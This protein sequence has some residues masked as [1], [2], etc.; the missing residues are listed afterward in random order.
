MTHRI[1]LLVVALLALLAVGCATIAG[2]GATQVVN[3][4][5]T[6]VGAE[7]W[8]GKYKNGEV[9]DL[10]NTGHQ[11]PYSVEISRKNVVVV[12]K[13]QGFKDTN[14]V[15]TQQVNGWFLGNILIGGIVGS[16]ID[17]STGASMKYDPDHFSV[18]LIAE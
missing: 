12:F 7:I 8:V 14:V 3:F 6:P 10:V 13:K 17:I 4:D 11:T 16:S 15:L 2:G 18:E 1:G 9:V 5:S